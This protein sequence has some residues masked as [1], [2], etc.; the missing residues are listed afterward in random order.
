MVL[1]RFKDEKGSDEGMDFMVSSMMNI[2]AC[3][4]G[5]VPTTVQAPQEEY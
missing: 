1:N 4:G 3:F 2:E 5:S